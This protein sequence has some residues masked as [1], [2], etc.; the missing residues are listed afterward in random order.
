MRMSY[1][2]KLKVNDVILELLEGEISKLDDPYADEL[3]III[4][5]AM[6]AKLRMKSFSLR[7]GEPL[8]VANQ[9]TKMDEIIKRLMD[10]Q[11]KKCY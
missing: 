11:N 5:R 7:N 1:E 9:I 6:M 10:L 3:P 2:S 8:E 4:N